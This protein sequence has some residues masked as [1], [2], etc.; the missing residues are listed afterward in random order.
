MSV[1]VFHY[2]VGAYLP[3]I[4]H[5]E[6]IWPAAAWVPNSEHPAVW[7]TTRDDLEPTAKKAIVDEEGAA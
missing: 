7:C 6:E 4:C 2:T 1:R 5:S 3:A